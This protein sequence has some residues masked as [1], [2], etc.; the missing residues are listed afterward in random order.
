VPTAQGVSEGSDETVA[1]SCHFRTTGVTSVSNLAAWGLTSAKG[2]VPDRMWEVDFLPVGDEG[3]S[4]DAIALRFTRP[5]GGYAHVIIDA[6]F[7]DDGVALVNHVKRYYD[8]DTVEL[9][10][11]TH[12]DAD[13]IGGMGEVVRGLNVGVLCVHRLG[14][15]GG[16]SLRAAG[17]VDDLIAV[18]EGR[19]TQIHEPF[20]GDRAFD[21][22]L[23]I[24]GP[25]VDWYEELVRRQVAEEASGRG[26][27]RRSPVRRAMT[28]LADR[29]AAVLPPELPFDDAGG[30]N[31]R[32][33]SSVITM[34]ETEGQRHLF[35][36]DAGVP[37]LDRAWD[38]L[39]MENLNSSPPEFA[40]LPHAGSRHNASS[41]LLT[42]LLGPPGQDRGG[43]AMASVA[44]K[45]LK[46]P[47]PRVVNAYLRR[48]YE[49]YETRGRQWCN[50][51]DDVPVRPGWT[52]AI[53]LEPMDES[54]ED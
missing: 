21:G 48:G 33:D 51:S 1:R 8:T 14:Q 3:Q 38:W 28:A 6:G 47:S 53:P 35:T 45:A 17:A 27:G 13:H 24:L 4:G 37:S 23:T 49:V 29:V 9:A 44:S 18:A 42:R 52:R 54:V 20:A 39:E 46:H 5:G 16:S 26:A 36:G 43:Q 12:P 41:E 31:P 22:A 19:G 25:D 40:Q 50:H 15:R 30:T 32:N 7:A 11:L 2:G 34:V 10:I